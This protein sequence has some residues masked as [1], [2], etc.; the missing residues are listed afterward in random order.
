MATIKKVVAKKPLVK[1]QPGGPT[2]SSQG[3]QLKAKGQAMKIEGQKLKAK[4]KAM[5]NQPS[6]F[7]SVSKTIVDGY[8]EKKKLKFMKG[9]GSTPR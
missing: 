6:F 1:K 9:A 2:T 4:G 5:A 7:Q 3:A 8:N